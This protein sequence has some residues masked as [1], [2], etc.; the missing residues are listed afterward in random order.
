MESPGHE[1]VG[2]D[3]TAGVPSRPAI[4]QR[5]KS[6]PEIVIGTGMSIHHSLK[7]KQH[8]TTPS[9][10]KGNMRAP[11][12]RTLYH[13]NTTCGECVAHQATWIDI[14]LQHPACAASSDGTTWGAASD[15]WSGSPMPPHN[16]Q[17]E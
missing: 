13:V 6:K 15:W 10:F 2:Y 16:R 5:S 12:R 11:M 14:G 9:D 17:P 8:G 7:M 3:R 4:R 1:L